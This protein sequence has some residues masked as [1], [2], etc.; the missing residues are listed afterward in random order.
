[1]RDVGRKVRVGVIGAGRLGTTLAR[2]FTAAGHHVAIANSRNPA[3]LAP[4]VDRLGARVHPATPAE[5]AQ[6]GEVVVLAVPFG[7]YRELPAD[8]LAG[9]IVIDATNYWPER[10][11]RIADLDA[12]RTTS[13]ELIQAQLPGARL[14][15]AF[16]AMRWDHLRD[17]GHE[18]GAVERYGIPVSGADDQAKWT[19]LDLIE[20]L[21]FHPVDAGNL[22]QG[23]R[24]HQPGAPVFLADLTAG[25][26]QDRL[27]VPIR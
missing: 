26:L 19:V 15:K 20:Q 8:Q 14:V 10:D 9:R 11:G 5:A 1:M 7:R 13:S 24:R 23:G 25:E 17:F 4:L 6:F 27:G 21:G 18:A 16:N 22:A 2:Q 3:T 12:D